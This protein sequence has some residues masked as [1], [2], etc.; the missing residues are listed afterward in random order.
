MTSIIISGIT[1]I[2][3]F[4]LFLEGKQTKL[5]ILNRLKN[6][7][8]IHEYILGKNLVKNFARASAGGKSGFLN[9]GRI[10]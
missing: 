7:Y 3:N 4:V 10:D 6:N 2:S 5:S 9:K 8:L 1:E